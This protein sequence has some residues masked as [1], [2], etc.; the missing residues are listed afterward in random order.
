MNPRGLSICENATRIPFFSTPKKTQLGLNLKRN[1]LWM[2]L[3]FHSSLQRRREKKSCPSPRPRV[4][5]PPINNHFPYRVHQWMITSSFRVHQWW[6]IT[7][8]KNLWAL[9]IALNLMDTLANAVHSLFFSFL[10][11]FVTWEVYSESKT[12]L[13]VRY[14]QSNVQT[15]DISLWGSNLRLVHS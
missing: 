3:C 8:S 10:V 11:L 5:I 12:I 15:C 1:K 4:P 13:H 2:I 7:M 14:V 9:K 6:S